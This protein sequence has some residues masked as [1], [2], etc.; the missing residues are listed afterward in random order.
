MANLFRKALAEPLIRAAATNPLAPDL[1]WSA[2]VER[3]SDLVQY[4]VSMTC[5]AM[6]GT[7]MLAKALDPNVN[8]FWFKPTHVAPKDRPQSY[9]ARTLCHTVLVPLSAEYGFSLGVSGRE[10]LNNQP[11]FRMER[12]DD[13]TPVNPAAQSA[14]DYMMA[15]VREVQV[16]PD[17][18]AAQTALHA[19]IS[20]R[21]RYVTQYTSGGET[22]VS[23]PVELI[24]AITEFMLLGSAGGSHAQ[25]LAAGVMDAALEV[26]RVESG[27]INDPSRHYP[28]DVCIWSDAERKQVEKAIEVRDKPVTAAD[29]HIFARRCQ[30]EKIQDCAVLLA[31][32]KQPGLDLVGLTH[33]AEALG[34]NL[35]LWFGWEPFIRDALFWSGKPTNVVTALVPAC[36]RHRLVD[37][38]VSAEALD[39]WDALTCKGII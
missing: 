4:R 29:I 30:S 39:N 14:F 28:G 23:T 16:L 35:K 27:R 1:H 34:V 8:L 22:S 11:Y 31:A 3:L 36:A 12:L 5:I 9:S 37:A 24:E 17:Q 32:P 21:R 10:P 33:W 20:V 18:A 19:F 15:L 7:A 38:E 2:K 6:L 13:G 26:E 25:A